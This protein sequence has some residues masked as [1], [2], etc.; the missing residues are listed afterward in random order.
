L[1]VAIYSSGSEL[2]QRRLFASLPDG[3]LTPLINAF[4]DT[5]VGAKQSPGSYSRIAESLG[6]APNTVLFVSDVAGELDAA[7]GAGCQVVLSLR[8]GNPPQA[9]PDRF[10]AVTTFDDLC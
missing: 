4:F 9:N 8:P 5:S 2:A 10:S 6:H 7:L 1:V 3:D